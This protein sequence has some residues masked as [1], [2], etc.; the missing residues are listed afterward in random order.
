MFER[1]L[2]LLKS[3]GAHEIEKKHSTLGVPYVLEIKDITIKGVKKVGYVSIVT[4]IRLYFRS[5]NFLKYRYEKLKAIT[6]KVNGEVKNGT[7]KK[8]VSKFLKVVSDYKHKIRKIKHQIQE[9]EKM[10]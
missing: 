8:D 2:A 9:E 4:T 10:K 6:K 3:Q 5:L 1:R 7:E